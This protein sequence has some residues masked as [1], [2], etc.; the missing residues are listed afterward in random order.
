MLLLTVFLRNPHPEIPA[1]GQ[2][3]TQTDDGSSEYYD[4]DEDDDDDEGP[5]AARR[6][7][8]WQDDGY[9]SSDGGKGPG[10]RRP[11]PRGMAHETVQ[12]ENCFLL[13]CCVLI[14]SP[15]GIGQLRCFE[16][17]PYVYASTYRA[18]RQ[19]G[20]ISS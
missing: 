7:R 17:V 3:V 14:L 5:E 8:V 18:L 16:W 13:A 12:V 15:V 6:G 10:R 1:E 2:S 19:M 11:A 4:E 20:G 9:V